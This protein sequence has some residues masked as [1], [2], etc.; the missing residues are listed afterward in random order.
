MA[1]AV[2]PPCPGIPWHVFHCVACNIKSGSR[3][4]V[5]PSKDGQ[6]PMSPGIP[7]GRSGVAS[8][9]GT[10]CLLGGK[11]GKRAAVQSCT[12]STE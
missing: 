11:I 3:I 1:V 5:D 8:S 4:R 6:D 7:R 9:G 12:E 10:V 2:T